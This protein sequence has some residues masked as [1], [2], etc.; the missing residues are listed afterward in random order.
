MWRPPKGHPGRHQ[1][2]GSPASAPA[3]QRLLGPVSE[4]E[5]GDSSEQPQP[6]EAAQR[7]FTGG[8][9]E[10]PLLA[11]ALRPTTTRAWGK[12]GR[13]EKDKHLPAF[14]PHAL[15]RERG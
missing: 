5:G 15:A 2:P 1:K 3:V 7:G 10:A 11:A 13:E 8:S 12:T 14:L 6:R 4:E 9:R